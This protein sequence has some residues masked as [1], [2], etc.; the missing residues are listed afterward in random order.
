MGGGAAG[1]RNVAIVY[2]LIGLVVNTI[3]VLSVKQARRCSACLS[4]AV[5]GTVGGHGFLVAGDGL[6]HV[7]VA[8]HTSLFSVA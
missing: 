4:G 3:S 5:A 1:W 6:G 7:R 2:G 8:V